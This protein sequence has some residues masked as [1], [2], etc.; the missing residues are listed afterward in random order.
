MKDLLPSPKK[1]LNLRRPEKEEKQP[2]PAGHESGQRPYWH[3]DLKW[4][5]GILAFLLLAVTFLGYSLYR[6]SDR[7]VATQTLGAGL[8]A[9]FTRDGSDPSADVAAFRRQL[10]EAP[11][12]SLRPIEGLSVEISE[13]E[14]TGK[15][16]PEAKSYLF[17]KIAKTFYDEGASGLAK[18]TDGADE[19]A[20]LE[21]DTTM[22]RLFT[23]AAHEKVGGIVIALLIPA[24][25]A[26][27]ALIYFSY[28][29][30]RLASPGLVSFLVG[31]P[32]VLLWILSRNQTREAAASGDSLGQVMKTLSDNALP[33]IT[34]PYLILLFGGL[35]LLLIAALGRLLTRQRA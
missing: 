34:G 6:F 25:I 2:T 14:L 35:A 12:H 28:R 3:K 19:R 1:I 10:A 27:L 5:S 33:A 29:W 24:I 18:L 13:A 30:G 32:G 22:I 16:D 31:L 20:Q 26:L 21:N 9:L 8:E 17:E 4:I 11:S 15:S 7:E 23:R